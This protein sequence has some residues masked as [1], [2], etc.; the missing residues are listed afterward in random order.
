MK[1]QFQFLK[2]MKCMNIKK[3]KKTKTSTVKGDVPAKI[4]KE[5][6]P[7]LSAPLADI[8]NCMDKRGEYANIW[9]L[10]MVTHAPKI[11][12]PPTVDDLR[13][14]YGLT[15]FSKIAEKILGSV[16]ISDV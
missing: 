3:R 10:E 1:S 6:A 8:I 7:E 2:P 5:F 9:K 15:N 13:M 4:I 12:P 11:H 14:I 16:L